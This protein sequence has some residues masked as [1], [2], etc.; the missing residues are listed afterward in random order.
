MGMMGTM[1]TAQAAVT[2]Y[3]EQNGL[4]VI[5]SWSGTLAVDPSLMID[6]TLEVLDDGDLATTIQLLHLSMGANGYYINSTGSVSSTNI[7]TSSDIP[8]GEVS[9]SFGIGRNNLYWNDVHISGGSVGAV[10]ELTFDPTRDV[11]RFAGQ[12]LA[13]MNAGSFSNTL[14]WTA[15]T[16]GDTISY[17]TGPVVSVPEPS[18]TLLLGLGTLAL[19]ARRK[20]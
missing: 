2:V 13:G 19:L 10:S 14:A 15:T 20:R 12:T 11:I 7:S 3:W 5:A 18:S 8:S 16:T 9:P 1:S 17:T 4:D 6:T